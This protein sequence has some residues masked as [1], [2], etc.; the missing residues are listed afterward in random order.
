MT[1]STQNQ[2]LE[3]GYFRQS[4][5]WKNLRGETKRQWHYWFTILKNKNRKIENL[6][7]YEVETPHFFQD[8]PRISLSLRRGVIVAENIHKKITQPPLPG[9]K[10]DSRGQKTW[11]IIKKNKKRIFLNQVYALLP[12]LKFG[13]LGKV[14]S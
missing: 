1:I 10:K 11:W 5:E 13:E 3:N 9:I 7:M 12:T 4:S 2:P 14:I 8:S 6:S